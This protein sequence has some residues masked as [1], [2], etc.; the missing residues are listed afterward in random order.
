MALMPL[1]LVTCGPAY[2]PVDRVRRIT[3]Q[4]TGELGTILA[5]ALAASGFEVL[6]LRGEAASHHAP[7]DAKIVGFS[8]NASLMT[9]LGKLTVQPE[10]VFHAAALCDFVVHSIEGADEAQ[11]IRSTTAELR[12]I[13][14]PAEKILPRLRALFPRAVIV[15]WKYE[16]DGSRSDAIRRAREQINSSNTNA[17]V[18]NGSAYGDG[19]GFLSR[20]SRNVSHFADKAGLCEFLA[21]WSL[22]ALSPP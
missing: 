19:F 8:T 20:E 3:N 11:K 15:G 13:L 16:L 7:K 22:E 17:C 6:C 21:K 2:E 12:L 14:R 1:A 9:F 5:E 10:A 18:V 4:S